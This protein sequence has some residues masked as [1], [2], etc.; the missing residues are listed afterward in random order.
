M[1][2]DADGT[3]STAQLPQE[4]SRRLQKLPSKK[5][6]KKKG[7]KDGRQSPPQGCGSSFGIF[8]ALNSAMRIMGGG[9]K[10]RLPGDMHTK[11]A[12]DVRLDIRLGKRLAATIQRG[13]NEDS[14][15]ADPSIANTNHVMISDIR[16]LGYRGAERRSLGRRTASRTGKHIV[17]K[18]GGVL[19]LPDRLL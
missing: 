2:K 7:R 15:T 14:L 12:V 10:L 13:P 5:A 6:R 8:Y 9:R 11:T 16:A 19:R 18:A 1:H 17:G 4:A 3:S